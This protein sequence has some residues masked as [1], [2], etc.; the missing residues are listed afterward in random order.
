MLFVDLIEALN[1]DPLKK[2]RIL[3]GEGQPHPP[4]RFTEGKLSNIEEHCVSALNY[5][6]VDFKGF[7]SLQT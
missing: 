7:L 4:A 2:R 6:L 1:V 3:Y 5:M